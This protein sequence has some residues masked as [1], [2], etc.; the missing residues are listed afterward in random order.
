M[1]E[2]EEDHI[3]AEKNSPEKDIFPDYVLDV[4]DKSCP[5]PLIQTKS[6]MDTLRPGEIL[7]IITSDP[8]APQNISKWS[9]ESGNN[10]LRIEKSLD[11]FRVFIQK[12]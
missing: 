9:K 7:E 2:L 1:I 12:R 5:Y 6:R 4:L 11:V 10:V 8:M 3:T